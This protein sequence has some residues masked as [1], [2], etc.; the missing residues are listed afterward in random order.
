MSGAST[1]IGEVPLSDPG[2]LE[3][4]IKSLTTSRSV[5]RDAMLLCVDHS[6]SAFEVVDVICETPTFLI[7][8]QLARLYLLS[9][10]LHNAGCSQQGA[11]IFRL[12]IQER[13]PAVVYGLHRSISKSGIPKPV[14]LRIRDKVA[15]LISVWRRWMLFSEDF[16][17]G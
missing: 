4:M 5:I 15:N 3:S 2:K 14:S 12:A 10:L 8:S 1:A 9:D 11:W 17:K 7:E 16:L 13:L 6:E